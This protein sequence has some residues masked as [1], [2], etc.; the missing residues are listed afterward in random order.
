MF[1]MKNI[2]KILYLVGV[3]SIV[4]I[5]I[6]LYKNNCHN[7]ESIRWYVSGGFEKMSSDDIQDS[8]YVN[9]YMNDTLINDVKVASNIACVIIREHLKKDLNN[10]DEFKIYSVN[11]ELWAIYRNDSDKLLLLMQ[12]RDGKILYINSYE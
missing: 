11:K 8:I 9:G 3:F 10:S 1:F 4:N 5:L 12:K 6:W 2:N 7:N